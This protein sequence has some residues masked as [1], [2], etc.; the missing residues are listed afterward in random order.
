[1]KGDKPV[2]ETVASA[3]AQR[4]LRFTANGVPP[5]DFARVSAS[6][7][8][9]PDWCADR[10]PWHRP[11]TADWLAGNLD[12]RIGDPAPAPDKSRA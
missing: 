8:K 2:H 9:W 6:V 7:E 4:E 10:S 11:L 12:G 1:V 3:I 5:A